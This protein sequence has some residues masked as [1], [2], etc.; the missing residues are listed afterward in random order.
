MG[1]WENLLNKFKKPKEE[2]SKEPSKD[3]DSQLGTTVQPNSSNDELYKQL[4]QNVEQQNQSIQDL[5]GGV[6]AQQKEADIARRYQEM[7]EKKA[8]QK[9]TPSISKDTRGVN[10]LNNEYQEAI[11]IMQAVLNDTTPMEESPRMKSAEAQK[12][13]FAKLAR[14]AQERTASD[15]SELSKGEPKKEDGDKLTL[16]DLL[17]GPML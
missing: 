9:R 1:A 12:L 5:Y 2:E 13:T 14:K 16:D 3:V 6:K 7:V 10:D 8:I 4:E 17:N 11:A 15:L